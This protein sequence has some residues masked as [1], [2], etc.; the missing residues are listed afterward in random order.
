MKF[1]GSKANLAMRNIRIILLL[2]LVTSCSLFEK[3]EPVVD[4]GGVVIS[5]DDR[6]VDEWVWAD[7]ILGIYDWKATF[8]VSGLNTITDTQ[9]NQLLELQSKGHEIAS[10]SMT[11]KDAV[12]YSN[13]HGIQKYLD[14]EI[15]PSISFLRDKG[16]EI[17]SFA[18]P[19]GYH[20]VQLDNALLPHFDILRALAWGNKEPS[21][22]YCFYDDQPL[23]YAFTIDSNYE[24]STI[25]YL[26]RLMDFARDNDKILLLYGHRPITDGPPGYNTRIDLLEAICSYVIENNMRFLRFKD[27]GNI[28]I[29]L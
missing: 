28:K 22:H 21:E 7:S 12:K 10:H 9:I 11:H 6:N 23:V 27:L 19:Y 5:F 1:V 17:S 24:H 14:D 18:W 29:L 3:E 15:I 2:V 25:E 26:T 4:S 20:N 16:F 8:F 13:E